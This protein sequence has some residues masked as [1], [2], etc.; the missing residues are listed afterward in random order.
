[1]KITCQS[2]QSKYNVADE[3]IKGKIVK[4][5]CRKCGATIVVDST[6]GSSSG[7]ASSTAA[8]AASIQPAMPEI[9]PW[10]VNVADNDQ[11]TMTV[12]DVVQAYNAGTINQ[13]TYVWTEGMEDW[14]P[15]KEVEAIVGAL[16]ESAGPP[17][18]VVPA[19]T[20]AAGLFEGDAPAM[21]MREAAPAAN[22]LHAATTPA[23]EP[24]PAAAAPVENPAEPAPRP[25]AKRAA[26]KR[27]PR[28]RDLF[29]GGDLQA[30]MSGGDTGGVVTSAPLM[31][32]TGL[33]MSESANKLTGERNENSVL[34]SLAVLTKS[35]DE[36]APARPSTTSVASGEDSGLIDLRALAAKAESTRPPAMNDGAPFS[37]PL[38]TSAPVDSPFGPV[39]SSLVEAPQKSRLPLVIGIGAV[40]VVMVVFAVFVGMKI[41]TASTPTPLPAATQAAPTAAATSAAPAESAVPSA[42]ASA[43][44]APEASAAASAA[45]SAGA[46]K[47]KPAAGGGGTYHPQASQATKPAVANPPPAST[48][49]APPSGGGKKSDCGC[50]GDLMCLMKCSTSH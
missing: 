37:T 9:A 24:Q 13:E 25:E 35:A 11:R 30:A 20:A 48:G 28:G 29:G 2:C 38:G 50:N 5:R 12:V 42:A 1:M 43:S 6:T 16:H 33:A 44:A 27:E 34:F 49:A 46:T 21:S 32:Q 19:S 39:G 23:A 18:S 15:L 26:V 41:G 8:A 45:A 10:H 17:P 4:I 7:A 47:P 14:K 3:K 36:R 22:E 31:P 40:A